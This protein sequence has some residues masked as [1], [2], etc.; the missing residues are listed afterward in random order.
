MCYC[1]QKHMQ[2]T[3]SPENNFWVNVALNWLLKMINFQDG[4]RSEAH[5]S[6]VVNFLLQ[7]Y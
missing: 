5:I 7:F 4:Q 1:L 2:K 6:K 3:S